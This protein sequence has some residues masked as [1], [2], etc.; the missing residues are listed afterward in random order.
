MGFF[1]DS[2]IGTDKPNTIRA[3]RC[4]IKIRGKGG[5]DL[6]IGSPCSD[7]IKGGT[8]NDT[9]Y[10]RGGGDLLIGGPGDDRIYGGKGCSLGGRCDTIIPGKGAD[11]V[12]IGGKHSN[13]PSI[14]SLAD[15]DADK[16]VYRLNKTKDSLL[17]FAT[18]NNGFLDAMDKIVIKG[19]RTR[20][21]EVRLG[22][23]EGA[24]PLPAGVFFKNRMI[25]SFGV[26]DPG[27]PLEQLRH[28]I[29]GSLG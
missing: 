4:S 22:E 21:L 19:V 20:Q 8:G 7:I 12:R 25:I 26:D 13:L 17:Q 9:I 28:Q 27:I 29:V 6:L 2:I 10:G 16:V 1:N 14:G 23:I 18:H 11:F 24:D 3:G 15:G 5:D